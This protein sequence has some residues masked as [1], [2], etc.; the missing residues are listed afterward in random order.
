MRRKAITPLISTVLL[1]VFAIGLGTLVMSWGNSSYKESCD[2]VE[3]AITELA[4]KKQICL[5]DSDLKAV[6]ENN[7]Y[8]EISGMQLVMV[9]NDAVITKQ[10]PTDI[11]PG[12]IKHLT[13]QTDISAVSKILKIRLIPQIDKL[14]VNKRVEIERIGECEDEY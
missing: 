3:I 14:C 6:I 9:L 5:A 4:G 12:E 13:M 10:Y 2:F 7:G 11:K 8:A 1:L